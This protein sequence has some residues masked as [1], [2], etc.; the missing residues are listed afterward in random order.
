MSAVADMQELLSSVEMNQD[1]FVELLTTLID[2]VDSLQNNP[3]QVLH[4]SHI[5]FGNVIHGTVLV[6]AAPFLDSLQSR[7]LAI[8]GRDCE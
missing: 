5:Y 1:R 4:F 6:D 7:H 3:S 2:N 8:E